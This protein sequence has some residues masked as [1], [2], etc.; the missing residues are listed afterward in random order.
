MT[1]CASVL[2]LFHNAASLTPG[3]RSQFSWGATRQV[4]GETGKHDHSAKEGDF[5]S[6]HI[7]MKRWADWERDR[8]YKSATQSRDS[9][10]GI[11][12]H[13]GPSYRGGS[14]G[15][16]ASHRQSILSSTDTSDSAPVHHSARYPTELSLPAPLA[17]A[18]NVSP[19]SSDASLDRSGRGMASPIHRGAA[20]PRAPQD[21]PTFQEAGYD[22]EADRPIL[23]QHS[24]PTDSVTQFYSTEPDA[25][26]P[27]SGIASTS[28]S[29]G[30]SPVNQQSS[31]SNN[32]FANPPSPRAPRRGVSL[33]DVGP[34]PA[35][36]GEG[37]RVVQRHARRA[38]RPSTQGS[39][40]PS[41]S[42]ASGGGPGATD[43][44]YGESTSGHSGSSSG[45][46][47]PPG[48]APPRHSFGGGAA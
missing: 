23:Y 25:L 43:S 44:W 16:P 37:V 9:M 11:E 46:H 32:P 28:T 31:A 6:S 13:A 38:S 5:D 7:A 21:Y 17:P 15:R 39:S 22:D 35:S 42:S 24:P 18:A 26:L 48:A 4:E 47:L 33:S 45:G 12:Q 40:I 19:A 36:S 3:T 2:F 1:T 41:S 27:P 20:P 29:N 10:Y 34:V 30:S 14:P 8:R